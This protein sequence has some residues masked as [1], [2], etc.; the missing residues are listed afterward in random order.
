VKR[1]SQFVLLSTDEQPVSIL[2]ANANTNTLRSC[3]STSQNTWKRFA[4]PNSAAVRNLCDAH[5]LA[6][7]LPEILQRASDAV[8]RRSSKRA[9]E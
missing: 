8:A 1:F 7:G 9:S 4:S 6:P 3:S 2:D 5:R